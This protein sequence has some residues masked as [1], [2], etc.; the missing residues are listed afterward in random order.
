M[1]LPKELRE[2]LKKCN[3]LNEMW[4]TLDEWYDL[5]TELGTI[6]KGVVLIAFTDKF[7]KL[8]KATGIPEREEEEEIEP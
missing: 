8:L 6:T 1:E 5:D 4:M 2:E 3:T 7:G